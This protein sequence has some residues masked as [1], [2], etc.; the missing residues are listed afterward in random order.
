MKYRGEP[1]FLRFAL[2]AVALLLGLVV[3]AHAQ[4]I[5]PGAPPD[6]AA[7]LEGHGLTQ[8]QAEAAEKTLETSPNDVVSH[9][10]LIDYYFYHDESGVK[11]EKQ[12]FWLIDHHPESGVFDLPFPDIY[13]VRMNSGKPAPAELLL[14]FKGHWERAAVA[15]P[16]DATVL[17][18][19]AMAEQDS[20]L[21]LE[22]ARKAVEADPT[23]TR[24][25]NMVGGLIGAA[26]LRLPANMSGNWTCV[27]IT[28]EVEQ[29]DSKFRNEIESSTDPEIILDAGMA[30]RGNSGVY[31]S[32]CGGNSDEAAAFG[33]RLIRKAVS[34]DPSLIDRRKLQRLLDSA[35]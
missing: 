32:R 15:H 29:A 7:F 24:C 11:W 19:T 8:A 27:P 4:N 31:G 22:Y 34:L 13:I 23:C 2:C 30:I 12:L 3:G 16:K 21:R 14:E 18:H 1:V 33:N 28:P 5:P 9:C 6:V 26:I 35:R 20:S 10:K 17:L 25:R